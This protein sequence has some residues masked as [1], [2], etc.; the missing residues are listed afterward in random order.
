MINNNSSL[1]ESQILKKN[2]S[3]Y[4]KENNYRNKYVEIIW[5][6]VLDVEFYLI[7][8]NSGSMKSVLNNNDKYHT[9]YLELTNVIVQ[10]F[11]ILNKIDKNGITLNFLNNLCNNNKM[12]DII[13]EESLINQL[14]INAPTDKGTPLN[15][16]LSN[17]VKHIKST[18]NNKSCILIYTDG[19][20]N[21]ITNSSEL[22]NIKHF[23]NLI[24]QTLEENP[25][26]SINLIVLTEETNINKIYENLDNT[27]FNPRFNVVLCYE[28]EKKRCNNLS[29]ED[30]IIISTIG[31]LD[32]SIGDLNNKPT[33]FSKIFNITSLL[34]FFGL[35][36]LLFAIYNK[37]ICNNIIHD[38]FN[39][40]IL[41]YL[42]L[43]EYNNFKYNDF[44]NDNYQIFIISTIIILFIIILLYVIY[45]YIFYIILMSF[46]CYISYI[47]LM[48][49]SIFYF[50]FKI[51][52]ESIQQIFL[53]SKNIF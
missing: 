44:Y 30:Y 43:F 6:L 40:D 11:R 26:I 38:L 20:P 4:L 15:N 5:K 23:E 25:N 29:K 22:D 37:D 28:L 10:A 27:I 32:K 17:M 12:I 2:L 7:I 34:L 13:N 52:L 8:D 21:D 53:K 41:K 39:Y 19:C 50:F 45:K 9:R 42:K 48:K 18:D 16:C 3:N 31:S 49:P 33:F 46:I 24:K 14:N 51:F 35:F 36:I 1:T 47:F